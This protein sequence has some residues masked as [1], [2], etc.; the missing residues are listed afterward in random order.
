MFGSLG[1][2][3]AE[4]GQEKRSLPVRSGPVRL[5]R[6]LGAFFTL[7]IASLAASFAS[8]SLLRTTPFAWSALPSVSS[9]LSPA[10]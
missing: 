4:I 3:R 8:P 7:S 9:F 2:E 5:N 1:W 10:A 6:L